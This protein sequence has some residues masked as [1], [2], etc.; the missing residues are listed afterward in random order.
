MKTCSEVETAPGSL[1]AIALQAI[2]SGCAGCGGCGA[3]CPN[4]LSPGGCGA[5]AAT[6][7]PPSWQ[8]QRQSHN[9]RNSQ[10]VQALAFAAGN[11]EV[12]EPTGLQD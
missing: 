4:N 11:W 12:G 2:A 8:A 6:T 10:H 5:G 9:S 1:Q 3:M 7:G